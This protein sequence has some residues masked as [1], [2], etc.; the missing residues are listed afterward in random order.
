MIIP[1]SQPQPIVGEGEDLSY[2]ME[3][4]VGDLG[5]TT[6]VSIVPEHGLPGIAPTLVKL[7]Y[8]MRHI[9]Y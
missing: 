2:K 7:T 3:V 4:A 6:R 8:Y 1:T 9:I 5:G